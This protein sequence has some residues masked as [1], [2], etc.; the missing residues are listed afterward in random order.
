[1]AID[2]LLD[3]TQAT[4]LGSSEI[5]IEQNGDV[6]VM[7]GDRVE[8]GE[9]WPKNEEFDK[10]LE[11]SGGFLPLLGGAAILGVLVWWLFF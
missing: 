10:E 1:M 9:A 3:R 2:D 5:I 8:D 7:P 6:N 4:F 11:G